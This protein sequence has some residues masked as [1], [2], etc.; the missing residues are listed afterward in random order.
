M[1]LARSHVPAPA[2][3]V[4]DLAMKGRIRQAVDFTD[5]TAENGSLAAPGA[6]FGQ[7]L[8]AAFDEAMTPN[9]WA[10]FTSVVRVK[11]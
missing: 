6:P 2:I 11:L 7:L 3:D 9:E 10:A 8:A 4:L 5:P 1:D